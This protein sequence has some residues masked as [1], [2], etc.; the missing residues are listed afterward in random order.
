MIAIDKWAYSS[1]IKDR[2]PMEKL[3]FALLTLSVCLWANSITV[4]I[5]VLL[6][7]IWANVW[8]GGIPLAQVMKLLVIP[9]VFLLIGAATIAVE[10]S[11]Q[12]YGLFAFVHFEGIYIGVSEAG[13]IKSMQIFLR[14][15]GAVSCLYYL[16]LNTPMIDIFASM[17]KLKMPL[18]VIEMMSLI[19]RFIFILIYTAETMIIAQSSRLGYTGVKSGYRSLSHLIASLF[20][21]SYQ[22]A[23]RIYTSL[24]A[25]GYDGEICVL[26][27]QKKPR[28]FNYVKVIVI[29]LI[30]IL[31]AA[32]V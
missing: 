4:S 1:K 20:V 25:R 26:E 32:V 7:M 16:T 10:I 30:L 12:S 28:V 3:S 9:L 27:E 18:L 11:G 6:I 14:A 31:Y 2:D 13:L 5:A 19:Y 24:E 21:R 17:K 23:D 29:N 8:Q 22:Q 15:L